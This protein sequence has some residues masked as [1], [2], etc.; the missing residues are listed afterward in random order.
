MHKSNGKLFKRATTRTTS[1]TGAGPGQI[2]SWH[3][4]FRRY[5]DTKSNGVISEE[6]QFETVQSAYERTPIAALKQQRT[7]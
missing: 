5:L 1:A 7:S 4:A 6:V 3:H 2:L